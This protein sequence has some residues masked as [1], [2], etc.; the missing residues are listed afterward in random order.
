[1]LH[2]LS[3]RAIAAPRGA[4]ALLALVS[5]LAVLV[6][7]ALVPV[8]VAAPS[9]AA[10][11]DTV[12]VT[13]ESG[14][15]VLTYPATIYTATDFTARVTVPADWTFVDAGV[16][17]GGVTPTFGED[18]VVDGRLGYTFT[19]R[20]DARTG[21]ARIG[22]RVTRP[23]GVREDFFV[24][25][26]PTG[27]PTAVTL[28]A[29]LTANVWDRVPVTMSVSSPVGVPN[30]QGRLVVAG[31]SPQTVSFLSAPTSGQRTLSLQKGTQVITAQYLAD[32]QHRFG[33]SETTRTVEVAPSVPTT[34]LTFAPEDPAPGETVT[35]TATVENVDAASRA[36]FR[37]P[38]GDL[39]F[40]LPDGTVVTRPV[41]QSPVAEQ[42]TARRSTATTTFV[43]RAGSQAVAGSYP[44]DPYF[45]A[46]SAEATLDLEKATTS[47]SVLVL[48]VG[49]ALDPQVVLLSATS[50]VAG[51]V[52]SGRV[53]LSARSAGLETVDLGTVDLVDGS[54]RWSGWLPG[55]TYDLVAAYEGDGQSSMAS[56]ATPVVLAAAPTETTLS[57][58]SLVFGEDAV[59]TVDVTV[60]G[61][62]DVVVPG[63]VQLSARGAVIGTAPLVD[64]RASVPVPGTLGGGPVTL[65]ARFVATA[66]AETSSDAVDTVVA[67]AVPEVAVQAPAV[68]TLGQPWTV[69]VD[70]R[71]PG[72]VAPTAAPADD[73]AALLA[74]PVLTAGTGQVQ[75]LLDGVLVRSV[76]LVDGRASVSVGGDG[77]F[78]VPGARTLSVVYEGDANFSAR[79]VD[80]AV[81]VE[82]AQVT[83]PVVVPPQVEPPVVGPG[84]PGTPGTPGPVPGAVQPVTLPGGASTAPAQATGATPRELAE[85]GASSR[86]LLLLGPLLLAGGVLV[87]VRRRSVTSRG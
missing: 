7:V 85:S 69:D 52:P 68:L 35:V 51:V 15:I 17:D 65:E 54:A 20:L 40:T 58:P 43:A 2:A 80:T 44:G 75:V 6:V 29:P 87:G 42:P 28:E 21:D 83:P 37:Y 34:R 5:A 53:R 64:G 24:A 8:A 13:S 32:A 47:L 50:S 76:T 74:A 22:A 38:T 82:A 79:A 70:V 57:V 55:G 12:T 18:G 77:W 78:S 86:L 49:N 26:T 66:E 27:R 60:P 73:S 45:A 39:T 31:M 63:E 16:Y 81:T 59:A 84:T 23:G 19:G 11:G 72:L 9:R 61:S 30:G 56:T 46:A 1:M 14:D 10:D 25:V 71:G 41:A 67:R 4:R 36:F 62:P 33:A 48:P 3:S